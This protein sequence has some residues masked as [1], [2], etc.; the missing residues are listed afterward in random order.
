MAFRRRLNRLAL[1]RLLTR[2]GE[3]AISDIPSLF[4]NSLVNNNL[5]APME[6]LYKP[7]DFSSIQ[8][9][10]HAIPD[11]ALEKLPSFKG[12]NAISAKTHLKNF[13]T[14]IAKWCTNHNHEDTKMKLFILSLEEDALDWFLEHDD[15]TFD[16]LKGIVDAFNERYG[17]R[18]EDRHFLV[19]LMQVRKRKM[20]LWKNL[21]KD[22]MI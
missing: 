7:C 19:P 15:N 2:L 10:P 6:D 16:S 12:N 13:N 21:I 17:D 3:E 1:S 20:R 22:S 9:Y 11:K 4:N 18:R 5:P 8:G 14:C